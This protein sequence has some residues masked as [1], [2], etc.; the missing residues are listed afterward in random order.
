MQGFVVQ[1]HRTLRAEDNCGR[2]A[3][4][5]LL[6]DEHRAAVGSASEE[7]IERSSFQHVG[8]RHLPQVETINDLNET[9]I[10]RTE[11][12]VTLQMCDARGD[13]HA[14]S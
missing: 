2:V 3:S 7:M 12:L 1:H 11:H 5:I 9:L 10:S 13:T 4:S 8:L 6:A 14:C